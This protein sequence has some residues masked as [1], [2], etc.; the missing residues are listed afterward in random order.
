V[1]RAVIAVMKH[2]DQSKLGEERLYLAYISTFLFIIKGSQA[3]IWRQE[4]IH[5]T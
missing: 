1:L 5:R 2:H 3:G 4:L